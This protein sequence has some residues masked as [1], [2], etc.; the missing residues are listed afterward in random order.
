MR[1]IFRRFERFRFTNDQLLGDE[2]RKEIN[3]GEQ[4]RSA[5]RFPV[6]LHQ[7]VAG[8]ERPCDHRRTRYDQN[9]RSRSGTETGQRSRARCGYIPIGSRVAQRLGY[10]LDRVR[11]PLGIRPESCVYH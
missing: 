6:A 5:F 4:R 1:L 3:V 2:R 8:E 10:G 7:E 9:R 11:F